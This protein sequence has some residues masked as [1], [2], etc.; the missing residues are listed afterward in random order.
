MAIAH[1]YQFLLLRVESVGL[2]K[3]VSEVTFTLAILTKTG[4]ETLSGLGLAWTRLHW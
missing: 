2:E 1:R 3:K 4:P